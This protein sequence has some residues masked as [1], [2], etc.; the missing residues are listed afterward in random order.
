MRHSTQAALVPPAQAEALYDI[1]LESECNA[2]GPE[3]SLFPADRTSST[4][5]LHPGPLAPIGQTS[6]EA[7]RVRAPRKVPSENLVLPPSVRQTNH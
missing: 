6:E 2:S 7:M 4:F 3:E 1:A 5:G